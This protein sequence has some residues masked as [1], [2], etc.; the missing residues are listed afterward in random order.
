METG[1]L[2]LNFLKRA[3]KNMPTIGPTTPM[4]TQLAPKVVSPPCARS[5]AWNTRT[6]R[7]R[8]EQ[9]HTP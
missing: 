9:A 5:K 1:T 7:D 4:D 6:I 3:Q 2:A 8:T